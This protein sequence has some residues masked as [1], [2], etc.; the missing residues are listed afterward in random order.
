MVKIMQDNIESLIKSIMEGNKDQAIE[1]IK[2]ALQSGLDVKE[3][4]NEG[5][6][7]GAE[8]IGNLYEKSEIYLP[9]LLLSADVMTTAVELLKPH[10]QKSN[11]QKSLGTILIGTPEGDIHSIG[12]NIINSLL[13]GQGY[14]V[15]DLGTDVPPIKFVEKAKEIN[16]DVI[17][18]SGLLTA[19]ITKMQET[20]MLLKE[21]NIK[22]KIIIGG[23]ILSKKSCEMIGADDFAVDGWDGIRKIKKLVTLKSNEGL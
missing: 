4:L 22:S 1:S 10:L 17:G 3:I 19:T 20:V 6:A 14:N 23:G 2:E 21:E 11:G 18:L 15:V 12:K 7:K 9:E 8:E 13:Q 5:I 16:P